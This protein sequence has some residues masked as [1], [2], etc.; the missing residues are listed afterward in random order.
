MLIL[1]KITKMYE[2]WWIERLVGYLPTLFQLGSWHQSSRVLISDQ[3]VEML[4]PDLTLLGRTHSQLQPPI[5]YEKENMLLLCHSKWTRNIDLT[6]DTE[7]VPHFPH[8]HVGWNR[9]QVG[10]ST[11][12]G[13]LFVYTLSVKLSWCQN[14]RLHSWCQIVRFTPLVSNC[15]LTLLV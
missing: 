11:L 12:S 9:D 10:Q 7:S 14:V 6:F 13:K 15:P 1:T 8:H 5:C 2:C 3:D 4:T